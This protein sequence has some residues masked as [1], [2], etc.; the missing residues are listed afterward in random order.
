LKLVG[1]LAGDF[2]RRRKDMP[3]GTLKSIERQPGVKLT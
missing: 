2:S 3:F 1:D